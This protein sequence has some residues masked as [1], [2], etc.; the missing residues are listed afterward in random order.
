MSSLDRA[1]NDPTFGA[2]EVGKMILEAEKDKNHPQHDEIA[3]VFKEYVNKHNLGQGT[4]DEILFTAYPEREK[5]IIS[6]IAR[7]DYHGFLNDETIKNYQK[8]NWKGFERL[9]EFV[10]DE[11]NTTKGYFKTFFEKYKIDKELLQDMFELFTGKP[12]LGMNRIKISVNKT[13]K[14]IVVQLSC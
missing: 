13:W 3:A 12:E 5:T 11:D 4:L 1:L 2:Y 14:D 9:L 6:A 10:N 7:M 8:I